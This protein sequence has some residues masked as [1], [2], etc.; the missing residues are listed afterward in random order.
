MQYDFSITALTIFLL[1]FSAFSGG[2]TVEASVFNALH[3]CLLT[4]DFY[5]GVDG[6]NFI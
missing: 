6:V 1:S 3:V 2:F 4:I 5:C